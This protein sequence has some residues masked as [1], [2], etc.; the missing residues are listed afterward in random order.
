MTMPDFMF[1][2]LVF[3][4]VAYVLHAAISLFMWLSERK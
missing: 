4:T 3:A 2:L 1:G